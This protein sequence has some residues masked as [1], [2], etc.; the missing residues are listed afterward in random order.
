MN[1]IIA[2][3][4]SMGI[5]VKP[6]L[7]SYWDDGFL[8][9]ETPGYAR[10]MSKDEYLLI[11]SALH[12]ADNDFADKS[13][14]LYKFRPLLEKVQHLYTQIYCPHKELS[15]D[16]T[17]IRFKGKLQF[18]QYNPDKPTPWGIKLWSLADAKTSYL[19]KFNVYLGAEPNAPKVPG[20]LGSRVVL[21][22]LDNYKHLG[23]VV[24]TDNYYS[25]IPLY[26]RLRTLD[27]GATGT[28]DKR[29]KYLPAEL[30]TIKL[31]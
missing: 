26:R 5:V 12:F 4:L 1:L 9:T 24:Y 22:I 10:V 23:H 27:F 29:R 31:K 28:I 7:Q 21:D 11:K 16:E 3:E 6:I 20:G 25:S 13:D 19:L 17:I 15:V 30:K 8:L 2:I 18:I 14:K